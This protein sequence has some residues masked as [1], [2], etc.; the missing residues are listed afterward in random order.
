MNGSGAQGA[1]FAASSLPPHIRAFGKKFLNFLRDLGCLPVCIL[2]HL[3]VPRP[4]TGIYPSKTANRLEKFGVPMTEDLLAKIEQGR[5]SIRIRALA[6]KEIYNVGSFDPFF[7]G[8]A[9]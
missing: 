2:L 5:C 8:L 9:P 1:R 3:F 6:M 7:E 4:K